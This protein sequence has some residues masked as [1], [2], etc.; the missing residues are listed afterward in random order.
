MIPNPLAISFFRWRE[1]NNGEQFHAR[2]ILTDRGGIR[3]DAGLDNG[4]PGQTTTVTLIPPEIHKKIWDSL[5]R[6]EDIYDLENSC[7][8]ISSNGYIDDI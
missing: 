2:Y 6:D 7:F 5:R 4:Q 8:Q 3:V 1:K